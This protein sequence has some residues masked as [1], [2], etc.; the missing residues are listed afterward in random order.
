MN[1][2]KQGLLQSNNT[3]NY[4]KIKPDCTKIFNIIFTV[5]SIALWFAYVTYYKTNK[6]FILG[7]IF[8]LVNFVFLAARE[9]ALL[10]FLNLRYFIVY[11][12]SV[13]VI[14][15]SFVHSYIAI[16]MIQAA[17]YYG[18]DQGLTNIHFTSGPML[19]M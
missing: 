19:Q 6:L 18:E 17:K 12:W 5:A 9:S 4:G 2:E 15:T 10:K 7:F 16:E 11:P 14:I 13:F 1:Q 3:K 8:P